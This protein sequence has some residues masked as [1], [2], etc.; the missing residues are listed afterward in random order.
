MPSISRDYPLTLFYLDEYEV[1]NADKIVFDNY[2][3]RKHLRGAYLS[4]QGP[5]PSVFSKSILMAQAAL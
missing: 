1:A 3:N 4:D 5:I 2:N